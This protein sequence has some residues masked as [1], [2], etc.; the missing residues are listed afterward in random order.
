LIRGLSFHNIN[1]Q[2]RHLHNKFFGKLILIIKIIYFRENIKIIIGSAS[3]KQDGWISTNYPI[4]DLTN[5]NTFSALFKS[6]TVSNFL[7]EHVWEHLSLEESAIAC[8]NC[9]L[10]LKK[11]GK[12]RIAVPDGFHSDDDYISQVKPGGYGPGAHDHKVIYN[13]QTLSSMLINTGFLVKQL[14]WFDENNCFHYEDWDVEDG[15]VMRST[16]FDLRNKE[17]PIAYTSLIIDALKP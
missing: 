4:L 16:R 14:E 3:T 5:E 11:G 2:I 8:R 9:F 15:M 17:N 7:A 13:Y 1:L 6:E 12:L 10:F